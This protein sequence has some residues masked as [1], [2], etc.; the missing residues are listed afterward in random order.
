MLHP[1]A[2]DLDQV[3][4][5]YIINNNINDKV[6]S[7]LPTLHARIFWLSNFKCQTSVSADDFFQA[8]RECWEYSKCGKDYENNIAAY[9][10]NAAKNDYVFSIGANAQEIA[11]CVAEACAQNDMVLTQV[12]T[13]SGDAEGTNQIKQVPAG[14]VSETDPKFSCFSQ[15]AQLCKIKLA[16]GHAGSAD[17]QRR[18]YE[19]IPN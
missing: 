18:P 17:M 11:D 14:F 6:C 16:E 19:S 10:Q 8:L 9:S 12:K 2:Y 13:Y 5:K 7:S 3:D 4:F 1:W 15:D